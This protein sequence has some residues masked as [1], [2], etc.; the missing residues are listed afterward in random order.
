MKSEYLGSRW[1][2]FDFHSHTPASSDYKKPLETEID[3]LKALMAEE[4]D[5]VAITDHVSGG[6]IDRLKATYTELDKNTEWYRP[7]HLFPGCEITVST[8][9]SRVHVLAIFDPSC[10]S[11]KI[12]AVL[13]Q[14]GITEGHGDAEET[15]TTESVDKVISIVK[16][17]GGTAIPAHID[18]PKG[19]LNGITNTNQ[20]IESWLNEIEA[21]EFVNLTFLDTVNPE[22]S[23]AAGHLAKL[24]GSDAHECCRLGKRYSWIKMSQPSIDGLKLAL[25]DH[26]FCVDNS[27][28]NPNTTPDLFLKRLNISQMRHCGRIPG[29]PA[30]F[31]LHPLFNAVIGGRGSG[32]STFIESV[33]LA[34]GRENEVAELEQIQE[35]VHS[36]REGV[37]KADTEICVELR[38]RDEAYQSI[39]KHNTAPFINKLQEDQWCPDNGKPE[40]RFHVSLYS[41]KQINALASNTNSLLEIIDRSNEVNLTAWK[42]RFD[43]EINKFLGLRREVRQLQ[44]RLD[45]KGTLESQKDDLNSDIE[46]FEK[47]GHKDI[48]NAYQTFTLEKQKVEKAAGVSG[49]VDS[50]DGMLSEEFAEL[51]LIEEGEDKPDYVTELEEIQTAFKGNLV[52]VQAQLEKLKELITKAEQDRA[53][54]I[55]KS[56]WYLKGVEATQH[57]EQV[58]QE[59]AEKGEELN[60]EQYESWLT[61]R[62]E[63]NTQL[64]ELESVQT[65]LDIKKDQC[66]KSL[67]KLYVLRRRL[68]IKRLKFIK[69]VIGGNRYV[70][71]KLLPFSNKTMIEKKFREH[72]GVEVS[73]ATSIYQD[74][75][76]NSLLYELLSKELNLKGVAKEVNKLKDATLSLA[77]GDDVPPYRI[78]NR[79]KT[80]LV[81]KI[82]QQPETFDR[83]ITWWPDDQLVVEYAKDI[84]KGKFENIEKGSAG[85]KAAAILAFLLSHGD[86]PIIVD[87]P[88]DDLDNALIYQLIVSQI[89]ENK[90]RRQIIMVTHNPNIVVNGDAEFVNVLH[91]HAGQVQVLESG[92]LCEQTV[93][94]HVCNIMEG[95]ATAFDKRY[96]RLRMI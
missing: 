15:C 42:Y 62:N 86:N 18:G 96:N 23:K 38:R 90:K 73:F 77:S 1:Y 49:L 91:F 92:G 26:C 30:I 20:E 79:L 40:E 22:L 37:T 28:D 66:D 19:L 74:D 43:A 10:D 72:I 82:S 48:F 4:V 56:S 17:A 45:N 68:Q 63:I 29:K 16:K 57:Y 32:K 12:A 83:L 65:N 53:D 35:E 51:S 50:I 5:C 75:Q 31:E 46:S 11:T 71:M 41:Q 70:K 47:G 80:S 36:F 78:D 76:P 39:W 94:D 34:L 44:E 14:C 25:H 54:A 7:L 59:Y 24:Q 85:Q 13:G 27:V 2:K 8:G 69:K 21:A 33:R 9:Q 64:E 87:Q 3:W 58:V 84:E 55:R 61:Q 67:R 95:G 93:R 81:Q 88:E 52:S 60:P 89:H 6:W